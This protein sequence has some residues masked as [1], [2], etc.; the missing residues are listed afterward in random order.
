MDN[1]RLYAAQENYPNLKLPKSFEIKICNKNFW[2]HANGTK[3]MYE[4]LSARARDL[5]YKNMT[6]YQELLSINCQELLSEFYSSL[7]TSINNNG[8]ITG[9]VI[10][11]GNWEFILSESRIEGQSIVVK[12]ARYNPK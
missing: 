6:N 4:T 12:H 5:S 8:L 10:R 7:E 1:T 11:G 2:V 9:R 3:H